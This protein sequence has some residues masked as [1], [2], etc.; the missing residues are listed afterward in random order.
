MKLLLLFRCWFKLQLQAL[1]A[2][3]GDGPKFISPEENV[4][5]RLSQTGV[6]ASNNNTFPHPVQLH[7]PPSIIKRLYERTWVEQVTAMFKGSEGP[8]QIQLRLLW[9]LGMQHNTLNTM[10]RK[11]R[12]WRMKNALLWRINLK[13]NHKRG[14]GGERQG[15][16]WTPFYTQTSVIRIFRLSALCPDGPEFLMDINKSTSWKL[17]VKKNTNTS[18]NKIH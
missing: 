17:W 2:K 4:K 13:V 5:I 1:L 6:I 12:L 16:G 18:F 9:M 15:E 7:L 14:G 8:L 3:R 11:Y 10:L